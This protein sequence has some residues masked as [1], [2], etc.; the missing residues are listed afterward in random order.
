M[1]TMCPSVLVHL[2][3]CSTLLLPLAVSHL[4]ST[5]DFSEHACMLF[6]VFLQSQ[7]EGFVLRQRDLAPPLLCHNSVGWK[8]VLGCMLE[9]EDCPS[10]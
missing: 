8:Q 6:V 3:V 9:S 4:L 10:S 7:E 1:P 5:E 2:S